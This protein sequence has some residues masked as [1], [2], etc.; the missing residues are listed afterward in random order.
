M[1][2]DDD[3]GPSNNNSNSSD[4]PSRSKAFRVKIYPSS[5]SGPFLVYFRK[6]EKPINVLWISS[7]IYKKYK[8]VKEIKK[9]SLDKLRVIFGSREDAN[10]L[11]KS[12]IFSNSYRVY[13][14]CD[15]CE[16]S[17]VIYDEFLNC[18]DIRNHGSGTFKNQS[19][20]PVQILDCER[21]SKL[22]LAGKDAKYVHSNCIKITFAGSVLPD[23][24][25]IDN[26]IFRVRLYYP[27]LMHCDHCLLF[28][29]T[30]NFCSNKQKCSKCGERHSSS[31]CKDNSDACIYCKQKH[32]SLKE[33]PIYKAN[34]EKLNKK[35][36]HKNRS[37]YAEILKSSE[38]ALSPN[39]FAVLSND[40]DTE[41]PN[42]SNFVYHPPIKRKRTQKTS[43]SGL[44]IDPEPQPSTSYNMNFPSFT[45][46]NPSKPVPGFK[47]EC[48]RNVNDNFSNNI[49][50][51]KSNEN[52]DISILSILEEIVDFLGLSDFWRKIIK[53]ILPFVATLLDKL[54]SFG[55]LIAS[56]FSF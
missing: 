50:G 9:I 33:C 54:N 48:S 29:H 21:L 40:Q 12:N 22:L 16:I 7:E 23:F 49:S 11:L 2:T 37:S 30:S 4:I 41:Q 38:D 42:N 18:D 34:Q 46:F 43:P 17:G 36:K 55:P 15:S 35:I 52:S 6:K 20:S 44:P 31:D 5:F 1:E 3:G 53:K 27:K 28:G 32:M 56:L 24:A 19:I 26:V 13:A 51:E 39:P 14:P 47:K 10:T 45:S 25:I 8:S